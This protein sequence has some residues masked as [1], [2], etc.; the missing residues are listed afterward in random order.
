MGYIATRDAGHSERN[1]DVTK[2]RHKP[3]DGTCKLELSEAP[4]HLLRKGDTGD[5]A[6]QQV[7]KDFQ[8]APPFF[9]FL[10]AD[11][12]IRIFFYYF[13]FGDINPLGLCKAHSSRLGLALSVKGPGCRRAMF[14]SDDVFL[15]LRQG[16]DQNRYSSRC[17]IDG[18][19]PVLDMR[20]I[21]ALVE[22]L[23]QAF[24]G[25]LDESGREFFDTDLK[26]KGF[27]GDTRLNKG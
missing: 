4:S 3:L 7:R 22:Q 19:W 17:P 12:F 2:Q 16:I 23:E 21:E 13:Q 8:A 24:F 9:Q 15:R 25:W 14:D 1:Y 6:G 18:H 11:E 5:E 20:S 26:E 10:D 27:H